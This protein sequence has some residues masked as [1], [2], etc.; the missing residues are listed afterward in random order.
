MGQVKLTVDPERV[1]LDLCNNEELA[2]LL[3]LRAEQVRQAL[4]P[5]GVLTLSRTDLMRLCGR[6]RV[7]LCEKMLE[8]LE[9]AHQLTVEAT[10]VATWIIAPL[11]EWAKMVQTVS[12]E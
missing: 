6:S 1:L 10:E 3:R 5:C 9:E 12:G 7:D 11:D 2:I 8:K 4:G